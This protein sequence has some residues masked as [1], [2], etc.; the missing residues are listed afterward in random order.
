MVTTIAIPTTIKPAREPPIQGE[1]PGIIPPTEI[2][3]P[4]DEM[5]N[6]HL[7]QQEIPPVQV[8]TQQAGHGPIPEPVPAVPPVLAP[9]APPPAPH[10]LELLEVAG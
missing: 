8:P 6:T 7:P 5:G 4:E 3:N 10:L 1:T 9:Q 2:F